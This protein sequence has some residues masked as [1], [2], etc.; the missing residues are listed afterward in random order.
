MLRLKWIRLT[1]PESGRLQFSIDRQLK[2]GQ[3]SNLIFLTPKG[4]NLARTA[5]NDL[6]SM[7]VV[8]ICDLCPGE[9]PKNDGNFHASHRHWL[10]AQTTHI[11]I[12]PEILHAG[13]CPGGSYIFKVS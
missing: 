13:S 6:L 9:R 12:A 8:Q 10:F 4:T 2:Q 1:V 7:E 11:D 5:H 3:I